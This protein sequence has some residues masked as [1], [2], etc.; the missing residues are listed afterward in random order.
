MNYNEALLR[1]SQDET[2]PIYT[3]RFANLFRCIIVI[4]MNHNN[5]KIMSMFSEVCRS[6]ITIYYHRLIQVMDN[7]IDQEK[8]QPDYEELKQIVTS[9]HHE[10]KTNNDPKRLC[11]KMEKQLSYYY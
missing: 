7:T 3:R 4:K 8:S 5:N 1:I 10:I 6:V 9:I 11:D 2:I